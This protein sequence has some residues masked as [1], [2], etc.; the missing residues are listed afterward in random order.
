M[1]LVLTAHWEEQ[2]SQ[3]ESGA[4]PLSQF[5]SAIGRWVSQL[6]EAIRARSGSVQVAASAWEA[7][8]AA[9]QRSSQ[10]QKPT[11]T[12][13]GASANLAG[14]VCPSC[15]RG[16]LELRNLRTVTNVLGMLRVSQGLQSTLR[17]LSPGVRCEQ[18]CIW[19]FPEPTEHPNG[20]ETHGCSF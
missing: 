4:L 10:P 3:V 14:E 12:Q 11:P 8:S 2:L 17:G 20:G 1:D 19:L 5:E 15:G 7:V 18:V 9:A 13:G 6:I 16:R